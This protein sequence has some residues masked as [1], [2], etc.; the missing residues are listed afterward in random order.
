MALMMYFSPFSQLTKLLGGD[1]GYCDRCC[2]S[3]VCPSVTLVHPAKTVGWKEM[4]F[5]R[6][7]WCNDSINAINFL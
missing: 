6:G 1:V 7:N 3:V 5:G 2:R 4:P